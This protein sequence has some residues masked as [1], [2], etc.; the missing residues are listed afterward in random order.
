M[1]RLHPC[2]NKLTIRHNRLENPLPDALCNQ[3]LRPEMLE[4]AILEFHRRI[5]R[6][7]SEFVDER[8]R[9]RMDAP[10]LKNELRKIETEARNLS[11]AI[12]EFGNHKSPTL[13]S[14]L[15]YVENRIEEFRQK[16]QQNNPEPELVPLERV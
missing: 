2:P 16:L 13:L 11:G 9:V 14:Q 5:H 1:R 6:N 7:L 3:F 10:R 8:N 4:Y 15:G 12:A